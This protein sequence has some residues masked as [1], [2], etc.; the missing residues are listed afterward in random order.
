MKVCLPTIGGNGL[1]EKVYNH[2]GSARYFTIYNT[3]TKET[4]TIQNN[5]DHHGHGTC[6][7]VEVIA[8]YNVDAIL[9]SGMGRRA[10][11]LFNQAGIK[12]FLLEGETVEEAIKMF[13]AGKLRELD[14]NSACGGHG[15]GCH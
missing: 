11:M 15:H 1:K 5:N 12:V 14:I 8:K 7:P 6:Q 10:V 3:E 13:E 2:F 4:D 9:T